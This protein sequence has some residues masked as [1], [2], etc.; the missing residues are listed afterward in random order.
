MPDLPISQLP[1]ADA[2]DGSELVP[3]VQAGTTKFTS[4]QDI[5]NLAAGGDPPDHIVAFCKV[6]QSG[7]IDFVHAQLNVLQINWDCSDPSVYQ[8]MWA[9]FPGFPGNSIFFNVPVVTVMPEL[10]GVTWQVVEQFVNAFTIQFFDADSN[11]VQTAFHIQAMG[12]L[13][14]IS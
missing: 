6:E 12:F 4:A 14:Q 10:P 8:V 5:A 2:L 13:N 3:V 11:P 7:G 9:E 1:A